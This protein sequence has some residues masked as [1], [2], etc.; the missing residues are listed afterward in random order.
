MKQ[1]PVSQLVLSHP[2]YANQLV[3]YL[4]T[5]RERFENRKRSLRGE[6]RI[7]SDLECQRHETLLTILEISTLEKLSF[8]G[9]Y[10]TTFR[11]R[12][13]EY[14][15]GDYVLRFCSPAWT[16]KKRCG[17]DFWILYDRRTLKQKDS[18]RIRVS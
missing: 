5:K 4:K 9:A 16:W 6:G 18:I 14:K 17:K 2:R 8:M 10:R 7:V 3:S 13:P 1:S 15:K 11:N 12:C